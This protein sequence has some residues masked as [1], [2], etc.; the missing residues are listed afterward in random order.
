MTTHAI[1][2][3]GTF[4]AAHKFR[5][6]LQTSSLTSYF[7]V[8]SPRIAKCE[9][10]NIPKIHLTVKEPP[11]DPS[12]EDYSEHVRSLW[13]DHPPCHSGKGF[14]IQQCS[15][16]VSL[17]YDAVDVMDNDKFGPALSAK[18][19]VIIALISMVRKPSVEPIFLAK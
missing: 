8:Y 11:W 16:L 10:E 2:L 5:I 14:S 18:I 19:K 6:L 13:S 17:A 7:D 15:Y 9:N 12:T 3:L 1:Q 4:D